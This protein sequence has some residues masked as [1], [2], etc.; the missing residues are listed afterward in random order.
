MIHR[1]N[2]GAMVLQEYVG[3]QVETV[4][5]R[6][7]MSQLT[8]KGLRL[9]VEPGAY[10][11]QTTMRQRL[12]MLRGDATSWSTSHR[13]FVKR[14]KRKK[15]GPN[16]PKVPGNAGSI[17]EGLDRK[18]FRAPLA[19]H[20]TYPWARPKR[21]WAWATTTHLSAIVSASDCAVVTGAMPAR[22]YLGTASDRHGPRDRD[23]HRDGRCP[24]GTRPAESKD[25]GRV[26]RPRNAA[27]HAAFRFPGQGA[28]QSPAPWDCPGGPKSAGR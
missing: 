14:G 6:C 26:M 8:S 28:S 10:R 24:P 1:I 12:N 22:G 20:E 23:G 4:S 13:A 5:F 7:E 3:L 17:C 15:L 2:T 25:A 27:G 16:L 21:V 18:A 11:E 19:D 9:Q